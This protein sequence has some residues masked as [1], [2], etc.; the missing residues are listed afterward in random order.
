MAFAA[1]WWTT[2]GLAVSSP[3]EVRIEWYALSYRNAI[4]GNPDPLNTEF[5]DSPNDPS[6]TET[7]SAF[8]IIPWDC[9]VLPPLREEL[10]SDYPRRRADLDYITPPDRNDEEMETASRA[11]PPQDRL[12]WSESPDRL[13]T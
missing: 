4:T 5:D 12:D 11:T 13:Q 7:L 3:D 2:H 6:C 1:C 8:Q 10:S 9:I